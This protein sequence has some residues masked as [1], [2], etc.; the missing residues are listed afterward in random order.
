MLNT[1]KRQKSLCNRSDPD[2][3]VR[4]PLGCRTPPTRDSSFLLSLSIFPSTTTTT[5]TFPFSR[6]NSNPRV[7]I[8]DADSHFSLPPA[9]R[10]SRLMS[11]FSPRRTNNNPA[12]RVRSIL[13]QR[14][15]GSRCDVLKR[16]LEDRYAVIRKGFILL[17]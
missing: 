17:C 9:S 1:W 13:Y 7:R 11:I 15:K 12:T 16:E 6:R 2:E 3:I 8:T 5:T 10:V 4:I 14:V